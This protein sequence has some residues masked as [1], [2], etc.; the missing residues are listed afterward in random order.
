M[1]ETQTGV[2]VR[3]LA[4]DGLGERRDGPAG[5]R[6]PGRRARARRRGFGLALE[7]APG[8]ADE[9]V[10]AAGPGARRGR[11]ATLLARRRGAARL[12]DR[13]RRRGARVRRRSS[14]TDDPR[15]SR[16]STSPTSASAG[17]STDVASRF[18]RELAE[19]AELNLHVRLIEGTDPQHVLA[20]IFKAVGAALGAGVPARTGT[21]EESTM[22]K[23]VVRTEA[24]PAPFQGAPYSQAIKANGLVF[25][26]GQLALRPG[27]RR[28]SRRRDR[29]ADRAGAREPARDPRG[30]G[31]RRS[32]SSSRRP[33]SC[34]TSTTSPA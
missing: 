34:R 27:R 14:A 30:G 12:G 19:A 32:T 31:H 26:S 11:S 20:A 13:A 4:R 3:R 8:S 23:E 9:A 22:S 5:A 7:V 33:S 6:P 17:S 1:T 25:V 24:A 2:R 18:L 28:R 29:G 10:A 15:S 21:E 16:T